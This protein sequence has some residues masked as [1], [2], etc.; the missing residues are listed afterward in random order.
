VCRSSKLPAPEVHNDRAACSRDVRHLPSI[1]FFY[2]RRRGVVPSWEAEERVP[3]LQPGVVTGFALPD[4]LQYH[5]GHTWALA[6]SPNLV[7]VGIDD[8]GARLVARRGQ[9]PQVARNLGIKRF[10]TT[11]VWQA[12][13]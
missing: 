5:P 6:E 9:R 10:V 1:D 8:F 4:N 3:R 11:A 13:R 12:G 2:S 7:R